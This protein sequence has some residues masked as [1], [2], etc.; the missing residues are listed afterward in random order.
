MPTI[1]DQQGDETDVK[2]DTG[3]AGD[4]GDKPEAP[5]HASDAEKYKALARKHEE[6]AKANAL[7]AKEL[8]ELKRNGMSETERAVAEATAKVRAE[9]RAEVAGKLAR[10]GFLA[11]AAGRIPNAADVADDI[12]LGRY[13]GEDG[14]V[15][16]SGLKALVDR[17]AVKPAKVEDGEDEDEKPTTR[18]GF[19]QGVRRGGATAKRGSSSVAEGR[20]LY[21]ELLGDK[22]T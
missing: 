13:V 14:E 17:L 10:Q 20:Q 4:Q 22:K 7:A 16:E 15:D 8:A 6:R 11:A 12:N 3:K 1:D 2:P 18:R 5:D 9:V 19:E 21:R